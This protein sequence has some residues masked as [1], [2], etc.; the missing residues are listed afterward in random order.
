MMAEKKI[1]FLEVGDEIIILVGGQPVTTYIDKHGAQRFLTN[2]V[3]DWL[4][5]SGRLDLNQLWLDF[6]AGHFHC[7]KF[8]DIYMGLGYSISGFAEVWGFGSSYHNKTG[9]YIEIVNPVWLDAK[10]ME[11]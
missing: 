4:F 7:D 6:Y 11:E 5:R 8:M 3:I 2:G 1:E 10:D 9:K